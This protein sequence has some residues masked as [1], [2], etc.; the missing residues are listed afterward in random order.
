MSGKGFSRDSKYRGV[1]IQ[2]APRPAMSRKQLFSK[3]ILIR[4][5]LASTMLLFCTPYGIRQCIR[6]R[7]LVHRQHLTPGNWSRVWCPSRHIE[8]FFYR[9]WCSAHHEERRSGSRSGPAR[10]GRGG[11][12]GHQRAGYLVLS[13]GRTASHRFWGG[14]F[15]G[16]HGRDEAQHG[17]KVPQRRYRSA[18]S[19]F[20]VQAG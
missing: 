20:G 1:Q 4:L 2:R 19:R 5:L 15:K 9:Q 14:T 11:K 7:H 6:T 3:N 10:R 12:S 16:P 18:V 13:K 17:R 8:Y